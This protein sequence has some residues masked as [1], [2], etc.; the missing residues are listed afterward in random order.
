VGRERELGELERFLDHAAEGH[1]QVVFV[2]GKASSGKSTLV[3]EFVRRAQE[4]NSDLIAAVGECNAQTGA[5]DPYL[6]FPQVLAVLIG[7]DDPKRTT[8]RVNATNAT[9]LKESVRISGETLLAV[10][11]DLIGIFVPGAALLAK[12]AT[13]AAKHGKLA[14]KLTPILKYPGASSFQEQ[15]APVCIC[16]RASAQRRKYCSLPP[17][18]GRLK[19][20]WRP[21][22]L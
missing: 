8:G 18:S 7:A 5:D 10:G 11:P 14:D 17:C 20:F 1:T 22:L 9:R 4:A 15:S 21:R 16:S 12:I 3:D 13:T 19:A 6:P 2:A